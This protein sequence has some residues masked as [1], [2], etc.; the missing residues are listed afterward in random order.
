M[1]ISP[2]FRVEMSKRIREDFN[3]GDAYYR[4]HGSPISLPR[5]PSARPDPEYLSWHNSEIFMG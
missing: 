2:D 4:V 5:S 3:N 1:T